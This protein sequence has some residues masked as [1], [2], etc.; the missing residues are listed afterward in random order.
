MRP[1]PFALLL[2]A[3]GALTLAAC[4]KR[5]TQPEILP[6]H[7]IS[8]RVR[9]IGHVVRSDGIVIETRVSDDADGVDV[10]LTHGPNVIGHALT[11]HGVYT[12]TRLPPGDYVARAN[13]IGAVVDS[14]L[15]MTLA[16]YDVFANDTL[17]F[18]SAGD[19]LPVPNPMGASADIYFQLADTATIAV[20][21]LDLSGNT[22]RTLWSG[23]LGGGLHFFTWDGT[24]E[25]GA[26]APQ[27]LFWATVKGPNEARAQLLF[28]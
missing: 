26:Q 6:L 16:N 22:V 20:R 24:D 4:A 11:V 3:A 25:H 8:G 7:S 14:T 23:G 12:F 10:I 13:V 18:T 5:T 27:Q 19:I 9:L 15:R 21:V 1:A 28:R 2:I 17:L